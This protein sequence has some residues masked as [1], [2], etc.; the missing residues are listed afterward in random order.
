MDAE[1][2]QPSDTPGG[3]QRAGGRGPVRF[4]RRWF[5]VIAGAAIAGVVGL[6]EVVR[7]IAGGGEGVT[8]AM[9]DMFGPFPVRSVETVPDVPPQDWVVEVGGLVQTPLRVDRAAW[10]ALARR[11][12]TVD[13]H[14]V[15][16]WSVGDVRW[17]GVSP[18]VLL[19]QAGLRPEGRYVAFHAYGGEYVDSLPLELV[20]H[21]QTLLA[22]ALDGEPLAPKHGGP[23]RLV[24]PQQ[25]GYKSVKWVTRLEV[26]D[27]PVRGYW[28]ERGYPMDAPVRG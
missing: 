7:R 26:T 1:R 5:L 16:G 28:E 3:A 20:E 11:E 8:S 6:L 18:A 22:D 15:E 27:A 17:G 14:C 23:L 9:N 21:P 19:D 13:F 12:E 2:G 4:T 10:S 25:L 24:V